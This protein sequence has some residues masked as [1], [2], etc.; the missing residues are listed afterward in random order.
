MLI[1]VK[2]IRFDI[3]KFQFSILSKCELKSKNLV[4]YH[5]FPYKRLCS[6]NHSHAD[7]TGSATPVLR[8]N[9]TFPN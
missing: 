9:P 4:T 2:K 6:A 7:A 8:Y 3:I 5:V 1:L